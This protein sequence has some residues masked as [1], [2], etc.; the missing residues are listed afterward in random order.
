MPR[1]VEYPLTK[2][3]SNNIKFH[4]YILECL[5]FPAGASKKALQIGKLS[6]MRADF[7]YTK[8]LAGKGQTYPKTKC[9]TLISTAVWSI[10]YQRLFGFRPKPGKSSCDPGEGTRQRLVRDLLNYPQTRTLF[11]GTVDIYRGMRGKVPPLLAG[12]WDKLGKSSHNLENFVAANFESLGSFV[13]KCR[14]IPH[15][16]M[17]HSVCH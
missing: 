10:I 12:H 14:E 16:I 2:R 4:P 15:T 7:D 13:G 9:Y 11:A 3:V 1:A 6:S 8:W 17:A 5:Q